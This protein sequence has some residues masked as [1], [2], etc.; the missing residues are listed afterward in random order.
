MTTNEQNNN[1]QGTTDD[2]TSVTS[3]PLQSFSSY[4]S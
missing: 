4:R 3:W 2:N 1:E